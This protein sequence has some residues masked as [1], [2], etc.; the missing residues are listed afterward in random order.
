M[1]LFPIKAKLSLW[2][3]STDET[4]GAA[5]PLD[6]KTVPMRDAGCGI[7]VSV[8][9][10][11]GAVVGDEVGTRVKVGDGTRVSVE[12]RVTVAEGSIATCPVQLIST[13]AKNKSRDE[14]SGILFFILF[15]QWFDFEKSKPTRVR[16]KTLLLSTFVRI[17]RLHPGAG[18]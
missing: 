18:K 8:G 4:K 17:I 14:N 3:N 13:T 7:G 15:S 1:S 5:V 2:R 6:K 9:G 16:T 10:R 12:V 11:V